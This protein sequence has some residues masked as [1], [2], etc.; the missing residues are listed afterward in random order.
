ME[1][2][3]IRT[4]M[5]TT[6]RTRRTT[7]TTMTTTMRTTTMIIKTLVLVLVL[8]REV[9]HLLFET[10]KKFWPH[11]VAVS[12]RTAPTKHSTIRELALV[13]A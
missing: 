9:R 7:T 8:M 5:S 1:L 13:P 10:L 4:F 2:M 12:P 11:Q 3:L 6:K